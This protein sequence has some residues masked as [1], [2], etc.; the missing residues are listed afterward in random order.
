MTVLFKGI[1]TT[2][3]NEVVLDSSP[4]LTS[5]DQDGA[6]GTIR[7]INFKTSGVLRAKIGID[8]TAETGA[9]SNSGSQFFI[10]VFA[11]DGTTVTG[12]MKIDRATGNVTMSGDLSVAGTI[13]GSNIT[14]PA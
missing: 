1:D 9:G 6:A 8:D 4:Y 10:E 14:P 2:T 7:A 13:S 5:V 3:G 11:D 12:L